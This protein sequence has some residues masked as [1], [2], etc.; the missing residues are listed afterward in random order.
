MLM[1]GIVSGYS[2]FVLQIELF[3]GIAQD[4]KA[5][6]FVKPEDETS[7]TVLVLPGT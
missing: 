2:R 6:E 5:Q 3:V 4:R 1:F 7:F